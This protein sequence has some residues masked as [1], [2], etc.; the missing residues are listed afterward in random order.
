MA[1]LKKLLDVPA[2]RSIDEYTEIDLSKIDEEP[3]SETSLRV[4][5]ADSTD[6]QDLAA[7][8]TAV[9]DGNLVLVDL[10]EP[11]TDALPRDFLINELQQVVHEINGDLVETSKRQLIV[12]PTGVGIDRQPL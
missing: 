3:T 9:Y 6:M 10:P 12:A 7:I 8:R 1:L 11:A 4:S 2:S 5:I